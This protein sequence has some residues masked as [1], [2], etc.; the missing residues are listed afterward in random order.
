MPKMNRETA[1]VIF[2]LVPSGIAFSGLAI[3]IPVL[4]FAV[5]LDPAFAD[6]PVLW[7]QVAVFS[8]PLATCGI[9][10]VLLGSNYFRIRKVS[11]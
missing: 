7:G 1:C 11:K 9:L 5:N 8:V 3:L 2:I 4:A 6:E 10:L